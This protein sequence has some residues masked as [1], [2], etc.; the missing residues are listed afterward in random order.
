V[1]EVPSLLEALR[2]TRPQWGYLASVPRIDAAIVDMIARE[3]TRQG[4][5]VGVRLAETSEEEDAAPW[6][7]LPSRRPKSVVIT[8]P[9]PPTVHAVLAQKLNRRQSGWLS[10]DP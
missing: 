8:E 10:A 9:L 6:T 5:V 4:S 2:G 1:D 7:R 3:A